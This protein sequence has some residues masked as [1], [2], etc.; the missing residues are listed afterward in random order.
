MARKTDRAI[1][2]FFAIIFIISS[3][4]LTVAVI[5]Q[6]FQD[7]KPDTPAASTDTS[8]D[9]TN[10][11][12]EKMD[13]FTPT[14]QPQTELKVD[15]TKVGT[16]KEVK[17]GDTITADYVGALMKDGTVFDASA[18]N[19]GPQTF[20][21]SGVIPGWTQGIPGM[22]EG[23]TR[24]LLIPAS[25]AYGPEG[26]DPIPPNADLVFDVTVVKVN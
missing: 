10:Q 19:G 25:L 1:A 17:A 24:R 15:D 21:L 13:N 11:P 26:K 6:L 2:W 23:G 20:P 4:I 12:E 22:K 16:G 7:N 5:Y 14:S 3:S 18:R 9:Q 8:Q